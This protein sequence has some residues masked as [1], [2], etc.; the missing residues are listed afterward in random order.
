MGIK[1]ISTFSTDDVA[2]KVSPEKRQCQVEGEKQLKFFPK[3]SRSAC[4]V[5]CATIK[6]QE[7]CRC[8]PYFF[9]GFLLTLFYSFFFCIFCLESFF[10]LAD[11]GTQL[12]DLESYSCISDVYGIK[13]KIHAGLKRRFF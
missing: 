7:R 3:Y 2:L 12:C 9:R 4:T 6:M 5:E 13:I 10:F 8:R 1:P 11:K